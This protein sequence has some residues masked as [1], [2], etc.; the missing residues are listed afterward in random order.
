MIDGISAMIVN[1][2]R[3]ADNG[4]VYSPRQGALCPYCATRA[5]PYATRKWDGNLRIR[6]HLCRNQKCALSQ[7]RISIKSIEEDT[8]GE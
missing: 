6:F 1:A 8:A 2:K 3:Q 5:K 4:V 7:M